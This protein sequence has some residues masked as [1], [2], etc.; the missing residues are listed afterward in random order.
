MKSKTV[1]LQVRG[2]LTLSNYSLD[3]FVAPHL[4]EL[5]EKG[6]QEISAKFP[7]QQHW[8]N[9]FIL[10][11]ILRTRYAGEAQQ[12]VFNFLRRTEMALCEH[13]NADA[14]LSRYVGSLASKT[15]LVSAYFRSLFHFE[16]CFAQSYQAFMLLEKL[17]QGWKLLTT[18]LYEK[19]DGSV[20]QRL[21]T[22]HGLSKHSE[23]TMCRGEVP[24]ERTTP[25]W[26]SNSGIHSDTTMVTFDE[27]AEL[28]SYLG[29]IADRL[30]NPLPTSA[31]GNPER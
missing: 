4:S 7:Q 10:N 2:H 9:N 11:S 5:S 24:P 22:L 20:L 23:G 1:D 21:G 12:L 28:L 6:T 17:L 13:E 26:I 15:P 8:L 16:S 14:H 18:R 27:L 29:N 3:R 31:V 25:L 30:S 19:R